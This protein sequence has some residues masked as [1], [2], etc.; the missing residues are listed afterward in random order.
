MFTASTVRV[1]FM[2]FMNVAALACWAGWEDRQVVLGIAEPLAKPF[3]S[4]RRPRPIS[5]F[6]MKAA[7]MNLL[8]ILGLSLVQAS[9][10]HSCRRV[11]NSQ[12]LLTRLYSVLFCVGLEQRYD[13]L[14]ALLM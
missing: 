7:R 14:D 8:P 1:N 5:A 9:G 6:R 12:W 10:G 3:S 13:F 2:D 11:L 4:A